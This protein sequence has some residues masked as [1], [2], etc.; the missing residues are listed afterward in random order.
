MHPQDTKCTP[1][2]FLKK[3]LG[4]FLLGGF[5]LEFG[6]IFRW[7]LRATTKKGRKPSTFWAKKVHPSDKILA[8]PMR[9]IQVRRVDRAVR[10]RGVC[11]M[12]RG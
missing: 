8:T 11:G 4:Q 10:H 9:S 6:G 7:S 2:R 12:R 5:D 1:V 3:F